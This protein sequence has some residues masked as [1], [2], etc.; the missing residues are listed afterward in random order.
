M[1]LVIVPVWVVL[2]GI[3]VQ[4]NSSIMQTPTLCKLLSF[5]QH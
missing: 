2:F 3:Y 4:Q 5:S 1:A